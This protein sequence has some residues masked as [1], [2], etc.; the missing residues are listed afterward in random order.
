MDFLKRRGPGAVQLQRGAAPSAASVLRDPGKSARLL[1]GLDRPH[2][3]FCHLLLGSVDWRPLA[4][5]RH[6]S[7]GRE[8][9]VGSSSHEPRSS[10]GKS[11][12]HVDSRGGTS[13]AASGPLCLLMRSGGR[14]TS[15]RT[16]LVKASHLFSCQNL[17][18]ELPVKKEEC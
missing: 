15:H 14:T 10:P 13:Q 7:L 17:W 8:R 18:T 1:N 9:P 6:A 2:R 12:P 5:G 11:C 16:Q 3:H 4:P